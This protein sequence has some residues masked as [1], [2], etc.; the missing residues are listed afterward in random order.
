MKFI[1]IIAAVSVAAMAI[2]APEP[3]AEEKRQ[4]AYHIASDGS[5]GSFYQ[6]RITHQFGCGRSYL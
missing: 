2:A 4:S 5:L 3:R 6:S 1:N